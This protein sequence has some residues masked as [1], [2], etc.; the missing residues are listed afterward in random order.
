[1]RITAI[2]LAACLLATGVAMAQKV[3]NA[4][5]VT[6]QERID[7]I[8]DNYVAYEYVGSG[9]NVPDGGV[10]GAVFG[11]L[12]TAEGETIEDVILSVS[13]NQTW[14][15]D[16]RIWLLYD[17]DCDGYSD[18]VGQVLCRD[19]MPECLPDGCCGCSGDLNGWYT[20]DDTAPSIEDECLAGFPPGCYGPDY[21][22]VGLDVFN[23][24]PSGGCWMLW[25]ADGA[26]G[27]LTTVHDW[28]AYVLY[29][30]TPVEHASW[31]TIKALY[32]Q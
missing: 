31:G 30:S 5:D 2:V 8:T 11:L 12:P 13:I 16:L 21:K 9:G 29:E 14:I 27:D 24:L 17:T 28:A 4:D 32:R 18:F 26:G 23:G 22:S 7:C 15:G 25:V 10:Y 6:V 3:D 20:F 19:G 1:M